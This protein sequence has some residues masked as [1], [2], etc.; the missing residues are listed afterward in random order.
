[1]G[2][3]QFG[4]FAVSSFPQLAHSFCNCGF[5][6][7]GMNHGYHG[8]SSGGATAAFLGGH[9]QFQRTPVFHRIPQ[10][11][12]HQ[13]R[14]TERQRHVTNK[15][16]KM[17]DVW[18]D[19]EKGQNTRRISPIVLDLNG[20][21]KAG[22]TGKNILGDGKISG[23]PVLFDLDPNQQSWS[24]RS[25]LRRPG[26]GAPS[27]EG[28]RW[29]GNTYL[30]RK[31]NVVGELKKGMYH[32]G[33]LEKREKTE[34]LS[35]NGGDGLLVWDVNGDGKI[36]SSKELFGNYDTQ[37][38]KKFKNGYEKLAH[39]F[40]KNKDG[41]VKGEEL[42]G[43]QIWKD[44]NGDAKVDAG[45]LQ[46]L[47]QHKLTSLNTKFN[48]KDMSSSYNTQHVTTRDVERV[49]GRWTTGFRDVFAGWQNHLQM[50]LYGGAFGAGHS[51]GHSPWGGGGF[52]GGGFF[53]GGFFF[54]GQGRW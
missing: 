12:Y 47:K 50:S 10:H 34:W 31:G 40:D 14:W 26:R 2:G 4:A 46:S 20:D 39:Y 7:G 45:E 9:F 19:H 6:Y 5:G 1:M 30:D 54:G 52:F 36:G 27:V 22:I 35:K 41:V 42:K 17:W 11:H 15:K 28:G 43:L 23:N 16:N 38:R 25:R 21:G 8:L 37:G 24:Y 18:F 29:A 53:G 3:F 48:A 44:A 13:E 32:W 51:C 33:E 49:H